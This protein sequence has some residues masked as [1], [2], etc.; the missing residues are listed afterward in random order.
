[1]IKSVE[2]LSK[3]A[4]VL[5]KED[6]NVIIEAIGSLREEQAFEGA[7][8]LITSFYN[9]TEDFFVRKVIEGFM[10]DVKDQSCVSEVI[11]E[12]RKNWNADTKSMLVSSC[13]Q[14]GLD[15]SGYSA[16]FAKIFIEGDYVTAL[17]CLTVIEESVHRLSS[18]EKEKIIRI[19]KDNPQEPGNEKTSLFAELLALLDK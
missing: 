18:G 15:Y 17:E 9:S 1:M 14:S 12:L 2:K 19:I 8:G 3:L 7:I 4:T 16:D 13:W 6:K 5:G 11:N 10:N